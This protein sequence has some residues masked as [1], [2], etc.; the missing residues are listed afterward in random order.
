M[1]VLLTVEQIQ[2][3]KT[4]LQKCCVNNQ[5]PCYY[6]THLVLIWSQIHPLMTHSIAMCMRV[7]VRNDAHGQESTA[8]PSLHLHLS[9]I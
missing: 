3:Y 5:S 1:R 8:E 7:R 4:E 2:F 9:T 6:Y